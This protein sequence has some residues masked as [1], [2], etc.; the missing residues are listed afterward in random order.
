MEEVDECTGFGEVGELLLGDRHRVLEAACD[1]HSERLLRGRPKPKAIPKAV[2]INPPVNQSDDVTQA[3][4][5]KQPTSSSTHHRA[6][7][8]AAS[9]VPAEL[10]SVSPGDG[11]VSGLPAAQ[12]AFEH[13]S[14]AGKIPGGW[15]LAPKTENQ[16]DLNGQLFTN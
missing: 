7:Y 1:R 8:P 11:K 13:R 2:W 9:C 16:H 14:D 12:Q 4:D 6:G 15:G 10:A 3:L 5:P